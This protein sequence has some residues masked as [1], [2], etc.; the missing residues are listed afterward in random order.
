[1]TCA[2]AACTGLSLSYF[3]R[4]DC[5]MYDN[6]DR[7]RLPPL[8]VLLPHSL[9]YTGFILPLLII[10]YDRAGSGFS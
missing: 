3:C 8:R 7:Q 6:V 5:C 1:M 2:D 10:L 4:A 9:P